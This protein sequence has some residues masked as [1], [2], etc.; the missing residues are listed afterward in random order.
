[1]KK[2][3][4]RSLIVKARGKIENVICK[5]ICM[6][7]VLSPV[8]ETMMGVP[9]SKGERGAGLFSFLSKELDQTRIELL[10][11]KLARLDEKKN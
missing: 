5:T 6:A 4:L 3:G 8:F 7:G 1:M 11:L 9:S 10:T 2:A